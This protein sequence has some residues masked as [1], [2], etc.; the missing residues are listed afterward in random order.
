MSAMTR[1]QMVTEL[2]DRGWSRYAAASIQKYLDWGLRDVLVSGRFEA[3]LRAST[4][5]TATAMDSVTITAIETAASPLKVGSIEGLSA[6]RSGGDVVPLEPATAELFRDVILPT[7]RLASPD[8]GDPT[9]YYLWD[10]IA[11]IYPKPTTSTTITVDFLASKNAFSGGSDT[12]GLPEG[13]DRAVIAAAEVHCYR[14]AH[15][16][17][18]MAVAANIMRQV[19]LEER[20]ADADMMREQVDR[21]G[22][23][24]HG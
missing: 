14:R 6:T 7:A 15:D 12:T 16:Y 3:N 9:H 22:R 13:F 2:Q 19:I 23:Y 21:I 1:D 20:N 18:G 17:E 11:Y 8:T 5:V 10:L 4:Q 24:S